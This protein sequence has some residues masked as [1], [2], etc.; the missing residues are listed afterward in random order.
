MAKGPPDI[1]A[2]VCFLTTSNGGR[3]TPCRSGYRC[4]ANMGVEGTFND[5]LTEFVGREL[6]APGECA[7]TK[8][9]FLFPEYQRGRLHEGFQSTLHEGAKLVATAQVTSV[10][11]PVLRKG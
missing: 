5:V 1:E 4:P 10:L 11:N 3:Q 6:V 8:L 2:D 7:R 9:W